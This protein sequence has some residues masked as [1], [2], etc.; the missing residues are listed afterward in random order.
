MQCRIR[1]VSVSGKIVVA[2]GKGGTLACC[3]GGYRKESTCYVEETNKADEA[4]EEGGRGG[5]RAK[6]VVRLLEARFPSR[7]GSPR[8][9]ILLTVRWTGIV[10]EWHTRPLS[11]SITARLV[12][13]LHTTCHSAV[14]R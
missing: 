13:V 6:I 1:A 8:P 2:L 4:F 7:P 12:L 11:A 3:D 10:E 9:G 5:G 14:T